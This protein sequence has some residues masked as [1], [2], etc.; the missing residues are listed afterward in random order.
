MAQSHYYVI[1]DNGAW[2][3]QCDG[4]NSEPYPDKRGALRDAI[5]LAQLDERNGWQSRVIAQCEDE[6]FR[7]EWVS[8][9]VSFSPPLAP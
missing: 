2:S 4:E 8:S 7:P 9:E 1:F 6:M 5:A 3:I